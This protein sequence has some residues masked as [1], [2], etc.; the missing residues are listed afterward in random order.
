VTK[1]PDTLWIAA[2]GLLGKMAS[3]ASV[4]S[5]SMTMGDT[6]K[7]EIECAVKALG[8]MGFYISAL[9]GLSVEEN[10]IATLVGQVIPFSCVKVKDQV[11][12]IDAERAWKE[13][14]IDGGWT[15]EVK[16]KLFIN[17]S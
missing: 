15:N 3:A 8:V 7:V 12:E 17:P 1:S 13:L 16:V 10:M 5:T 6:G 9:A 2:L 4:V 11:L 14:N